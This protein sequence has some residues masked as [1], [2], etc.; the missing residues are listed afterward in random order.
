[1]DNKKKI[2]E[3][4]NK[5]IHPMGIAIEFKVTRQTIYRVLRE[6]KTW[7]NLPVI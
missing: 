1:M 2:V 6:A 4:F 7:E 5:R 3:M